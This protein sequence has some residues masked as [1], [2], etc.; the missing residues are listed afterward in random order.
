MLQKFDVVGVH[1]RIDEALHAYVEQKLRILDRYVPKHER[2][3]AHLEVRLYEQKQDSRRL[4]TCEAILRLP[5]ETFALTETGVTPYAAVDIVKAKLK[6]ELSRYRG[7]YPD[8]KQR[9]HL[10][11]RL[12]GRLASIIPGRQ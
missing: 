4:P 1:F 11:G 3:V 7:E 12:R 5:G 10:F 2:T 8:G 9:R 6:Q